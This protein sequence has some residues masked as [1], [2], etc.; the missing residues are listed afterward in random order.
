MILS[1]KHKFIFVHVPKTGGMS[2][3]K[4]LYQFSSKENQ[5]ANKYLIHKCSIKK[6]DCALKLRDCIKP[7]IWKTYYKFAFVRNPFDW[8]VSFYHYIKKD[9]K[10]PRYMLANKLNFKQFMHWFRSASPKKYPARKG[11]KHYLVDR[12]G[13]V[14]VDFIGRLENFNADFR[15]VCS[16]L[17]INTKIYHVNITKHPHYTTY[18]DEDTKVCVQAMF[19]A[20]LAFFEY[21]F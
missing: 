17:G 3:K 12:D 1:G 21:V 7:K 5:V 9:K 6:H 14:L 8:V 10:D 18:Y 13:S 11:Q 20:D 4:A 15:G 19:A 16:K 2:I